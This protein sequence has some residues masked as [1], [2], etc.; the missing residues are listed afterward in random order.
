MSKL[1]GNTDHRQ[2]LLLVLFVGIGLG[3][4]FRALFSHDTTAAAYSAPAV[5]APPPLCDCERGD[6]SG[7]RPENQSLR[8]HRKDV[9]FGLFATCNALVKFDAAA[10][11]GKTTPAPACLLRA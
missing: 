4:T 5:C 7:R 6:C 9:L 8:Q 10:R 1:Y 2:L 3:Y 11:R